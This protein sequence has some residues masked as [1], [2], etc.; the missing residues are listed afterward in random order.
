MSTIE[1]LSLED[2]D[3]GANR[4][5]WAA[6]L[7]TMNVLLQGQDDL[8]L[9]LGDFKTAIEFGSLDGFVS[10]AML[11]SMAVIVAV[12][13]ISAKGTKTR[14][15]IALSE[16][17]MLMLNDSAG[18]YDMILSLIASSFSV[19]PV[20]VFNIL[21]STRD[22][23][24]PGDKGH[25]KSH[26]VWIRRV[27]LLVIWALLVAVVVLSPRGN[28]D[29]DDRHNKEQYAN[30]DPCNKRG[31]T[32]YWRAMNVALG[33]AIGPPVLWLA[34]TLFIETGFG[35][36]AVMSRPWVPAF[37]RFWDLGIAWSCMG[38]MWGL[39]VYFGGMEYGLNTKLPSA[40]EVK[41]TKWDLHQ[42]Y[43]SGDV[44]IAGR[45]ENYDGLPLLKM[46]TS[47]GMTDVQTEQ[48]GAQR[49]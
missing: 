46:C 42:S 13:Y 23:G 39:L 3:F 11:M 24:A 10:A 44:R 47:A 19:F 34:I 22:R 31:G 40:Y 18:A 6:W 21:L 1:L 30:F 5:M 4:P 2:L 33:L 8:K 29:Y 15:T 17:L 25:R 16:K 26:R 43:P 36:K 41:S 9:L 48:L 35:S 28:L 32:T 38:I 45:N 37:W 49:T 14:K 20:L 12:I 7:A 27:G